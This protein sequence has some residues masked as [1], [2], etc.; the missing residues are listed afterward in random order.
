MTRTE[1]LASTAWPTPWDGEISL[2]ET[3]SDLRARHWGW[4]QIERHLMTSRV[5]W[6]TGPSKYRIAPLGHR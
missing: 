6:D 2:W 4:L 5:N 1:L 3:V